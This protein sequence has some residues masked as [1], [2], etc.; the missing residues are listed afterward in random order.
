MAEVK[1]GQS[2]ALHLDAMRIQ[3]TA[4]CGEAA[5]IFHLDPFGELPDADRADNI[6]LLP[7]FVDCLDDSLMGFAS[8]ACS[9]IGDEM[10]LGRRAVM[11]TAGRSLGSGNLRA[12]QYKVGASRYRPITQNV[13]K[14]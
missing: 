1:R 11:F 10:S 6:I 5:L 7:V 9:V 2:I 3:S 13:V 14:A 4:I 8:G 12:Y